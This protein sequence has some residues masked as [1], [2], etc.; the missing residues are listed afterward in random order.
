MMKTWILELIYMYLYPESMTK[1]KSLSKFI[2]V[3][4]N[5]KYVDA[6]LLA[7][8]HRC[9]KINFNPDKIYKYENGVASWLRNIS[10][11]LHCQECVI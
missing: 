6:N 11:K 9:S 3:K 2:L 4:Y 7:T 10:R 8:H 5:I 1:D